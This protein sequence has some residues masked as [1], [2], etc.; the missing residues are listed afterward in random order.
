MSAYVAE[1]LRGGILGVP[2]ASAR[3]GLAAWG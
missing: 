1:V 3:R 2:A